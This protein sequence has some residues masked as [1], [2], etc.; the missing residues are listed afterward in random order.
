MDS[1]PCLDQVQVSAYVDGELSG[2]DAVRLEG[3]LEGCPVC[4]EALKDFQRI[5]RAF[6]SLERPPAPEAFVTGTM[7][8]IA[9][10]P[11]WFAPLQR[12]ERYLIAAILVLAVGAAYVVTRRLP[13]S[14]VATVETFLDRSLDAE[15]LEVTSIPEGHLNN[16]RM[17]GLV[18]TSASR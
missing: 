4:R 3:H 13:P 17:L 2:D 10:C 5:R 6:A 12:V 16:D 9:A 14:E 8:R 18:L 7:A 11:V 15:I 1:V